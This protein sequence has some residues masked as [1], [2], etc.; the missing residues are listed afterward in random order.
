MKGLCYQTWSKLSLANELLARAFAAKPH[1]PSSMR[2]PRGIAPITTADDESTP[3][4]A[5]AASSIKS[6]P[7]EQSRIFSMTDS[8]RLSR[9]K[10]LDARA[11][12][13]YRHGATITTLTILTVVEVSKG[14]IE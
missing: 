8:F 7:F 5:P 1:V 6:N 4:D 11:T 3:A 2:T 9:N 13:V 14:R 12:L 10:L